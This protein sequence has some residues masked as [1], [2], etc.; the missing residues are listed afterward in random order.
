MGV[1]IDISLDVDGNHTFNWEP[2]DDPRALEV[3]EPLL[4]QWNEERQAFL[5]AQARWH[6]V[7]ERIE[8][9][10]DESVEPQPVW[11]AQQRS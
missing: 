10:L 8:E 2:S 11:T 5:Q 3:P 7:V 1:R 6:Q 9:F 4:Q